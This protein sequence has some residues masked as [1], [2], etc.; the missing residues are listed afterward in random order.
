M[1]MESVTRLGEGAVD[2][3]IFLLVALSGWGRGE[4]RLAIRGLAGAATVAGAGL[5]VRVLK[6]VACRGRP[7]GPAPG[8]F[9]TN[10]PCLPAP[11]AEAS[12]PS[13]HATTAFAA[14]VLLACWY[15]RQGWVFL[16]LAGL[17]GLSRIVLGS[18]FPSDV[19]AGALLGSAVA[20]AVHA[21]VAAARR[22]DGVPDAR[23]E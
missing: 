10:F 9:F 14:A 12:F 22:A 15:P 20:L 21:S 11:Y 16:G 3:G 7:N 19:L 23:H 1:L 6:N 2:I 5:L 17:V 18:H 8:V 13:G 4:R